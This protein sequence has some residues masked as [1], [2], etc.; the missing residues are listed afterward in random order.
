M[1]A[2]TYETSLTGSKYKLAHKTASSNA[3][4]IPTVKGQRAREIELLEDAK[5]RLQGLPPVH[6]GEKVKVEKHEKGQQ[7]LDAL[8]GKT[9]GEKEDTHGMNGKK[10]KKDDEPEEGHSVPA[11]ASEKA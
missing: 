11:D 5:R 9:G 1:D 10:R 3:W 7:K 4:S 6:A 2:N 8:F